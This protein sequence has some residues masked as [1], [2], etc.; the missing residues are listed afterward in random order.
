[1]PGVHKQ[2]AFEQGSLGVHAFPEASRCNL[3][4]IAEAEAAGAMEYVLYRLNLPSGCSANG[5]RLQQLVE[6]FPVHLFAARVCDHLETFCLPQA[7]LRS[8]LESW[9]AGR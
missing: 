3:H 7:T 9:R 1:M 8:Q 5:D 4:A 6:P 2:R